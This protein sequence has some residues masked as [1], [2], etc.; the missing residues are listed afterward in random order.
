MTKLVILTDTLS[1]QIVETPS[2][3]FA[4]SGMNKE[5]LT[6]SNFFT[7]DEA[8]QAGLELVLRATA[9]K[10]EE[11]DNRITANRLIESGQWDKFCELR[12]WNP[13]IVNEGRLDG[14]ED[15]R[16]TSNEVLALAGLPVGYTTEAG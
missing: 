13:W 3:A 11:A 12:G 14:D 5:R 10:A 16:L 7:L 9:N 1:V 2:G 8:A 6:S 15:L 4:V